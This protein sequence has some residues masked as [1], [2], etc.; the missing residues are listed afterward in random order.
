MRNP[1]ILSFLVLVGIVGAQTV[2]EEFAN[3][4]YPI[5]LVHGF[6]TSLRLGTDSRFIGLLQ[7]PLADID[8]NSR[9]NQIGEATFY[10]TVQGKTI[11]LEPDVLVE[12]LS[13]P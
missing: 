3:K 13:L 4:P 6:N 1:T 2:D 11:R 8:V 12:S 5:L 9:P 7:A 10:G